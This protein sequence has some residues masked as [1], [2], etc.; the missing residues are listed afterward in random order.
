MVDKGEIS[1]EHNHEEHDGCLCDID[2]PDEELTADEDLP[3]SYG[4]VELA[5][6]DED[7]AELDGC[8]IV[9]EEVEP[10]LDEDLPAATGGIA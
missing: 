8:D 5:S 6:F 1:K 2:I 3:E 7:E 4:G 9:F 10:T